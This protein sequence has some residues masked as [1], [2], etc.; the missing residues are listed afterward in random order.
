MSPRPL[1][2]H[3]EDYDVDQRLSHDLSIAW[4]TNDPEGFARKIMEFHSGLDFRAAQETLDPI[5]VSTHSEEDER[6]RGLPLS[7]L[8]T[9]TLGVMAL[10]HHPPMQEFDGKEAYDAHRGQFKANVS[11]YMADQILARMQNPNPD[12]IVGGTAHEG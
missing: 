12:D 1:P 5:V 9:T 7:V 10:L 6:R 8:V 3:L 4:G 2:T 11:L